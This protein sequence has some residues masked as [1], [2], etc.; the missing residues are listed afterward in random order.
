MRSREPAMVSEETVESLVCEME[1]MLDELLR[2]DILL[3]EDDMETYLEW[4]SKHPRTDA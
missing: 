4:R 1:R 3:D 2:R